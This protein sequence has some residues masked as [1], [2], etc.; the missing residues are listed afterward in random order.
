MLS[1]LSASFLWM[2]SRT[3]AGRPIREALFTVGCLAGCIPPAFVFAIDPTQKDVRYA[4][5]GDQPLLLDFY[6]AEIQIPERPFIVWVHGGAWKG[7]SK[8]DVPILALRKHGFAIASV[9]YR[10]SPVAKFPAQIHD[11]KAA[12]QY[13]RFHATSLNVAP[14][15]VV[16]AGSSAGGHLA[17]LSA[18]TD[19]VVALDPPTSMSVAQAIS[20]KTTTQ[21]KG[22]VSFFGAGNLQ[23]ILS[24]STLAFHNFIMQDDVM[25]PL[26]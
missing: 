18:V 21:V 11:I 17:V 9:D 15:N 24:Q 12:I 8:S 19:G 14:D 20:D 4:M 13:L 5:V 23:S 2:F 1:L 7:G 16:L 25:I 22:V 10:L 6:T 26:E 3:F